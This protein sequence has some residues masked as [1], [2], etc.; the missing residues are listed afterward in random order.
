MFE[1]EIRGP[2]QVAG[3]QARTTPSEKSNL[4]LYVSAL[5]GA[6][7]QFTRIQDGSEQGRMT[8]GDH[9]LARG[10][11][12][13]RGAAL[14]A[15]RGGRSGYRGGNDFSWTANRTDISC[16][17]ET[18]GYDHGVNNTG[19]KSLEVESNCNSAGWSCHYQRCTCRRSALYTIILKLRHSSCWKQF[20]T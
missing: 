16:G 11:V 4:Y 13:G 17:K 9:Q 5:W 6:Q 12:R 1:R 3:E 8:P 7:R 19:E 18:D 14:T 15:M 10:S 20:D 2:H